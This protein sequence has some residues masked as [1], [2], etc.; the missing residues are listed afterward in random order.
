MHERYIRVT[1]YFKLDE[2]FAGQL[3]Q[4]AVRQTLVNLGR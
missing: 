2:A 3:V 1:T 4:G